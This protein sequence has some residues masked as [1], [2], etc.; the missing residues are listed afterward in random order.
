[1]GRGA[2]S[3]E[4]NQRIFPLSVWRAR[5][6][7]RNLVF[8]NQLGTVSQHEVFTILVCHLVLWS[9]CGM[10]ALWDNAKMEAKKGL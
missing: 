10:K 4:T 1:M 3:G 7:S 5:R 8:T 6:F 9:L 2:L